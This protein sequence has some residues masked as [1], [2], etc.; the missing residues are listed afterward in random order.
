VVKE[1]GGG[2]LTFFKVQDADR[3]KQQVIFP[4]ELLD[5]FLNAVK[6]K[7]GDAVVFTSGPW[8]QT[9]KALGV[10]R[11]L[12][13]APLVRTRENEWRFLWVREFPLFEWDPDAKRWSP[14]HHM[15]TM[16]NPEHLD[17]IESDPGKVHAQLYD[18]VLNG[19]ELGSGSI[20]IHRTDIQERVMKAIG[21]SREEAYQKFGFLLEAYQFASPPHGGIGLGFDRIVMLMGHRDS[22][23]DV[24]AFPKSASAASLMDGSPSDVEPH[25]LKELAIRIEE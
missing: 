8:E 6:A 18:L 7:K 10:L 12:L 1:A 3:E 22:L 13:G 9:L 5:E 23:R 21:L 25:Q 20:R 4:G 2:G 24:I 19:T 11:S 14:R 15:F 17:F 16:P